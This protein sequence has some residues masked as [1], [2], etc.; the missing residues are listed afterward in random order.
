MDGQCLVAIDETLL[1]IK[2][3]SALDAPQRG[4][5]RL[6]PQ[7]VRHLNEHSDVVAEYFAKS[8]VILHLP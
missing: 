4:E 1:V 7:S 5:R 3:G 8:L 6:Y 2:P